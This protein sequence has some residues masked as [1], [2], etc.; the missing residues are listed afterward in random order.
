MAAMAR[1]PI[2][3]ALLGYG[4]AGAA[5][6]A[7]LIAADP[8]LRLAAIVTRDE[9]RRAAAAV[10]HPE[11]AL[12]SSAE[13]VWER[14]DELG[15]AVV[16]TPN[17]TH[18]PLARA[19]LTAGL[20]VV[21]D[22]PLAATA[23]EARALVAEARQAGLLLA[24]FQNR[25]WDGDVLTVRRLIEAGELGQVLRFES[26]FERWRPEIKQ[27][28]RELAGAEE[29]GGTLYDLGPHLIDQA[30]VLFGP[31]R[32]VYAERDV[33][34]ADAAVDD[35]AFVALTHASGVRS[36]L[37]MSAVAADLGPR[38]RVLGDR[39]AYVKHGLD[40]Q[41]A[42]LRAGGSPSQPGWGEEPEDRWGVVGAGEDWRPVPTE[43]GRY[44]AFYGGVAAALLDGAPSPVPGD[45]VVAALELLDAARRS[46]AEG[47]VVAV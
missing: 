21:V 45:E 40:I 2:P 5:F 6:H 34:R 3:V 29:A 8:R 16:A 17:R 47:V 19:A 15:L 20:P 23:D 30:L 31:V 7:P 14:A 43:P 25:R 27:G 32:S 38:L 22:K 28:W 46:A 9:E 37:W 24:T 41:E 33:R 1:D 39:A 11:A 35:D 26:R 44:Q 18:V 12:L 42:A 4:L 13:E 36:H 10:A